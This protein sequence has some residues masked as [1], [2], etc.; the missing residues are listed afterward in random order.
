MTYFKRICILL[1][2]L[3]VLVSC[4]STSTQAV[5][6]SP[7]QFLYPIN[8]NT[9]VSS[10]ENN[11]WV[12]YQNSRSDSIQ[13]IYTEDAI[14]VLENGDFLAGRE[15][16]R[17]F[18]A[19][20]SLSIK[21]IQ[22]DTI[23]VANKDRGL[24]YEIGEYINHHHKKHKSLII[25]QNQAPTRRRVFEFAAQEKETDLAL[26][27]LDERRQLW[28]ELCNQHN[29]AELIKEMYS[30]NTLYY[31]NKPLIQGHELLIEEYQYMNNEQYKLALKPM[32]VELV[33]SEFIFEIG[34]CEGSYN[35]KYI[36][37]WKKE[38]DGKWK[39]FIDSN[40]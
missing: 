7:P 19:N 15:P 6:D 24:E 38:E 29:A 16:I 20:D 23:I 12:K 37:I 40:I 25:W 2:V 33:N 3:T 5:S 36:L 4:K 17:Q 35:G 11:Q 13:F 8:A 39:I 14:K 22:S 26:S 28:M 21:S 34:Q 18:F 1:L 27:E 31:N 30:S 9:S 32:I 10:T